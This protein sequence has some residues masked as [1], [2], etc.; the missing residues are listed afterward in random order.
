MIN[1]IHKEDCIAG[2]KRLTSNSVQVIVT[3]PPYNVSKPYRTYNDNLAYDQY[4][5]FLSKV[6]KECFRA[7]NTKGVM[8][9]NISNCRDNQFKAYDAAYLAREAG[10]KLIDTILWSKPNPRYYNTDRMLTNAYEFLFMFAKSKHY[11]FDKYAIGVPCIHSDKLKC[12][13]NVW[14]IPKITFNQFTTFGHCAMFPVEL[15]ELCIKLC[16]KEGDVVLDPFM[17]AGTTAIAAKILD[18]N[19]I[20]FEICKEYI[21][22]AKERL[23]VVK[24][25]AL[26]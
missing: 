1:K 3:S 19:Y 20:G 25:E 22:I 10:F 17:G 24:H 7:L 16:S 21:D 14:Q 15:P 18:R 8:F 6:F 26:D 23:R 5:Q 12:R 4:K 11:A 13:T 2:M 9:V